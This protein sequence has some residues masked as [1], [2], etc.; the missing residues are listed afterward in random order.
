MAVLLVLG[1]LGHH[2]LRREQQTRHRS[3][4]LQCKTGHL[5]RVENALIEHVPELARGGVPAECTLAFLDAVQ[6]DRSVLAGVVD[7]LAQRLLDRAGEDTDTDVL[8]LV[9]RLELLESALYADQRHAASRH[10]AFLSFISI[11]V[12]APTLI[13]ATPPESFA[14]RSCSFSLS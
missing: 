10:H 14:T 9:R 12:A 1:S 7:D 5:G 3:G 11:S 4:V 2:H 13:T 8:V 6:D